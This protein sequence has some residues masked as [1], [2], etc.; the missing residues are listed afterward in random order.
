[1]AFSKKL[2][3]GFFLLLQFVAVITV[4]NAAINPIAVYVDKDHPS[5]SDSN[6]GSASTP[7]KS[8]QHGLNQ[9]TAGSHLYVKKSVEPYYGPYR[10]RGTNVGGFT[11]NVN[12]TASSPI[13]VEGYPGERPVINQKRGLSSL[14]TTGEADSATKALAGFYIH[15]GDYLTIR[16]F[17][18]TQTSFSGIMTNPGP[19]R[20]SVYITIEN[21]LIHHLYADPVYG[22]DN[23]GGI[24]IDHTNF[25]TIRNNVIHDIYTSRTVG[26]SYTSEQYSFHSGIHG[27]RPGGCIIENNLIY[28]VAKG[29]YQ[30]TASYEDKDSN[31]VRKNIF[32]NIDDV[33]YFVGVQGAGVRAAYNAKFHDNIVYNAN[34]GVRAKVYETSAQSRG[35]EIYNNTFYNVSDA[36]SIT[37]MTDVK[38][39]N[40]IFDTVTNLIFALQ[41]PTGYGNVNSAT[42]FDNNLYFNSQLLWALDRYGANSQF[43]RSLSDWQNAISR[44]STESLVSSPDSRSIVAAPQYID[45]G[46]LDFSLKGT[47]PAKG[48][49]ING[50]DIGAYGNFSFVGPGNLPKSPTEFR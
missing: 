25:C 1:M 28:N 12:G 8:L 6:N 18:I 3:F 37:G 24:R 33:T 31:E 45:A 19:F 32:Y 10:L 39:Y 11:I 36:I 42:Q 13:V 47:S 26:N 38:V 21:M 2:L 30:K 16:N 27:F 46:N 50:E 20:P 48:A 35:M 17:E 44:S 22:R 14:L 41:D 29:V 9:L 43:L 49:G 23:L 34:G 15:Q 5:A 40:N 4:S 7:W